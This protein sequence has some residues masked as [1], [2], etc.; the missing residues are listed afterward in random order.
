MVLQALQKLYQ[1]IEMARAELGKRQFRRRLNNT[2]VGLTNGWQAELNH[3]QIVPARQV[4]QRLP[5]TLLHR[6]ADLM[7]RLHVAIQM[8]A[9]LLKAGEIVG[10]RLRSRRQLFLIAASQFLD[11]FALVRLVAVKLQAEFP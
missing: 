5:D 4:R 7:Q 1:F 2:Q 8:S 9:A 6:L 3:R 11:Y 10:A